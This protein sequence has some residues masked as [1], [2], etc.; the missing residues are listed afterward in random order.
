MLIRVEKGGMFTTVQDLGRRGYQLQGVPVAGAMDSLSMRIGNVMLG[1]D[2]NAASLEIT[3][4]GPTLKI[5]EGEGS[6]VV[7][8]ADVGVLKNGAPAEN[9]T[10]HL[11]KAGD[12]LEFTPPAAG[13]RAY[14]CISGG[15]DV[16]L[17]MGSRSTYT[18]GNFGGH[19]GR[20]LKAGDKL[21]SGVQ[22]S[23]WWESWGL[24]CPAALRPVRSPSA[25]LRVILGP[26]DDAFTPEGVKT[27][28]NSEYVIS[29]S[30]DRMGYRMEG[31]VIEHKNAADI[32]S[33]AILLGSV[34]IPGH[35]QPIVMLADRQ[36]TGGYTK[37]ATVCTADISVLAQRLPGQKVRFTEITP[38]A[39]VELLKAEAKTLDEIKQLRASWRS[40][41]SLSVS[42]SRLC[43]ASS[44]SLNVKI[45]GIEH[46][47]VWEKL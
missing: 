30:A 3:V 17:V 42:R 15:F 35:G 44:G 4:I 33:D 37:I 27:F 5:E 7:A 19:E 26:Q 11:L 14:L 32:V 6:F 23:L 8:G 28:L 46:L 10:V 36:T 21:S 34:Q 45:D 39:A 41:P 29:A 47:V 16:P 1:N 2:E 43:E 12:S 25:P 22:N 13:A 18:R 20:A 9:W 31:P 38:E 24:K 40:R